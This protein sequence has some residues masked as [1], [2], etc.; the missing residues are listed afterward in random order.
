MVWQRTGDDRKEFRQKLRGARTDIKEYR[1]HVRTGKELQG[2]RNILIRSLLV[3]AKMRGGAISFAESSRRLAGVLF[4]QEDSAMDSLFDRLLSRAAKHHSRK[5]FSIQWH[6]WPTTFPKRIGLERSV[7]MD[8][9]IASNE[10]QF[11]SNNKYLP[12]FLGF[13]ADLSISTKAPRTPSAIF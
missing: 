13:A 9:A 4:E 6:T 1:P 11:G 2:S 10:K 5:T 7:L 12:K 3:D 8:K